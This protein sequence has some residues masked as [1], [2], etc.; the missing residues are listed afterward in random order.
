MLVRHISLLFFRY[1]P[2]VLLLAVG[3]AAAQDRQPANFDVENSE[4]ALGNRIVFPEIKG[5]GSAMIDCFAIV[6]T[7]GKMKDYGCY[8]QDQMDAPFAEA[9]N[10]AAKKLV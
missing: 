7:G 1:I 4:K 8:A 9:V 6:E 3:T 10:Y 5:D 2:I